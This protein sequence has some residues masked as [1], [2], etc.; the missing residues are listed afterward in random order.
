VDPANFKMGLAMYVSY[1]W[2]F[3]VLFINK[4]F[5]PKVRRNPTG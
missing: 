4:Y 2:L 3:A 5:G 1:F